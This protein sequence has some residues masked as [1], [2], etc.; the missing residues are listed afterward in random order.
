MTTTRFFNPGGMQNWALLLFLL[1]FTIPGVF[2]QQID[3]MEPSNPAQQSFEEFRQPQQDD[4]FKPFGNSKLQSPSKAPINGGQPIGGLPVSDGI[5]FLSI[6][7]LGFVFGKIF[8]KKRKE[9][10]VKRKRLHLLIGIILTTMM[11]FASPEAFA[12]CT[13]FGLKSTATTPSLCANSGS[14]T[15]QL[16]KGGTATGAGLGGLTNVKYKLVKVSDGSTVVNTTNVSWSNDQFTINNVPFGTFRVDMEATCSGTIN[17]SLASVSVAGH[18]TYGEYKGMNI[19]DKGIAN[20]LPC[21]PSGVYNAQIANGRA[22][23]SVEV[24]KG[25]TTVTTKTVNNPNEDFSVTGLAS[26]SYTM[27]ITD[28]CNGTATQS[29]TVGALSSNFPGSITYNTE[30]T[31]KVFPGSCNEVA[32]GA[33]LVIDA[34][35]NP[36]LA[37]FWNNHF[38]EYYEVA[39]TT[40]ST[41]PA[42]GSSEW[43]NPS[44]LQDA[45]G[46]FKYILPYD[47]YKAARDAGVKAFYLHVRVKSSTCTKTQKINFYSP[48]FTFDWK[49]G[50]GANAC[51]IVGIDFS[52][53]GWEHSI[54]CFPLKMYVFDNATAAAAVS[55]TTPTTVG[56]NNLVFYQ[57]NIADRDQLSDVIITGITGGNR[58]YIRIVDASGEVLKGMDG[59]P[60]G[61]PGTN[62]SHQWEGENGVAGI[63][64]PV[65]PVSEKHFIGNATAT[66]C[67]YNASRMYIGVADHHG[68]W[69]TG[70]DVNVLQKGTTI[71]FI[72][73]PSGTLPTLLASKK[74]QT[75]TTSNNW[76]IFDVFGWKEID[77]IGNIKAV[78]GAPEGAYVFEVAGPCQATQ[79]VTIILKNPQIV[80]NPYTTQQVCAGLKVTFGDDKIT[81]QSNLEYNVNANDEWT[82]SDG[83]PVQVPETLPMY[84]RLVDGPDVVKNANGLPISGAIINPVNGAN[85]VVFAAN[86]SIILTKAGTYK[87]QAQ[88]EASGDCLY[89]SYF[90][91]TYTPNPIALD[92]AYGFVC[93]GDITTANIALKAKNGSGKYKY[94]FVNA[95]GNPLSGAPAAQTKT[96]GTEARFVG[97]GN[98]ND[99]F[100]IKI[101]DTECN[102][103]IIANI[104]M[105]DVQN[106]GLLTVAE[107]LDICSGSTISLSAI[108]VP[109]TVTYEWTKPDG[110]KVSGQ[111]LTIPNATAAMNGVYTIHV[112][113]T[114]DCYADLTD[115]VTINV[116]PSFNLGAA[117]QNLCLGNTL[118]I[119]ASVPGTYIWKKDGLEITGQTGQTLTISN[120]S[121]LD[122]G[123]YTATR[124]VCDEAVTVNITDCFAIGAVNDYAVTPMNTPVTI[125]ELANDTWGS[126]ITVNDIT[127]TQ[128]Q[129]PSV[130]GASVS[131]DGK[132]FVYTPATDF[133][134]RDSIQYQIN[135]NGRNSTAWIYVTIRNNPD[136]IVD[137]DCEGTPS[138]GFDI[139]LRYK[140][141]LAGTTGTYVDYIHEMDVPLVG[142]VDGDGEVEILAAGSVQSGTSWVCNKIH[143]FKGATGELKKIM[144][145]SST[146]DFTKG[147]TFRAMTGTRAIANIDGKVKLFIAG[148]GDSRYTATEGRLVCYDIESGN[149]EWIS[150]QAYALANRTGCNIL[151][152]DVN[153]DGTPE[154]VVNDRIFNAKTGNLLLD[155]NIH[156]TGT[157][158]GYGYGAGHTIT[159]QHVS[160]FPSV[161]DMDNDGKLEFVAGNHI[162]KL[163]IKANSNST[164]DNSKLLSKTAATATNVGDGATAIADI[165]GDGYLDVIVTRHTAA[166]SGTPLTTKGNAVLYAWNGK[167]GELFGNPV[168]VTTGN[169][170]FY[171]NGP[172]IPFIGDIDGDGKPE[173][174]LTTPSK[175]YAYK[176]NQ[177]TN[178]LEQFWNMT[179]TDAS[180]ST[181]LTMFDFN[182]DGKMKLVYRDQ[183]RLKVIDGSTS[184]PVDLIAGKTDAVCFSD[185]QNEYPVVADVT[186]DGR[187]NIVVFGSANTTD[188]SAGKGSVYVYEHVPGKP[189]APSRK[190]WNQW[191][192]NAV[193]VNNDLTIPKVQANPATIFENSNCSKRPYNAF[194][195]Q[196]T[197][198]KENGCPMWAL[199]TLEWVGDPTGNMNGTSLEISG[200]IV[201]SGK[202]GIKAPLYITVY[203]NSVSTANAL[204][205]YKLNEDVLVGKEK[206]FII[207]VINFDTSIEHLIIR[208]N[209]NTK[210]LDSNAATQ[211]L[212]N[213]PGDKTLD[214]SNPKTIQVLTCLPSTVIDALAGKSFGTCS[215][216]DL[217]ASDLS[218]TSS[219]GAAVSFNDDKKLVYSYKQ[220]FTGFDIVN[221]S[222]VCN[223]TTYPF[224]VRIEVTECP[225][226]IVIADCLGTPTAFDW[227]IVKEMEIGSGK[228]ANNNLMPH[229][230]IVVGD[231]NNDG[232]PDIAGVGNEWPYPVKIFWGP[233]FTSITKIT[234]PGSNRLA[235]EGIAIAK[236]KIGADK[237]TTLLFVQGGK[238]VANLG[239][240]IIRADKLYAY[241]PLHSATPYWSADCSVTGMANVADFN[242]DG[243]SE[244]F[245]GNIIYDAATGAKLCDGGSNNKGAMQPMGDADLTAVPQAA[246]IFGLGYLSLIA[247][248][249]IYDVQLNSSRAA[250]SGTMT[251]AK[252][253]TPPATGCGDGFTVVADFDNDSKMEV[254][255]RSMKPRTGTNAYSFEDSWLYLW[256]PHTDVPKILAQEKERNS[257]FGVP[258][259]G[260]ING[261]RKAEIVTLTANGDPDVQNGFRA[262]R[263]NGGANPATAFTSLWNINHKD[264][265]GATGM[266]LFDFN[267][268]GKMEIVYRDENSLDI[269]DGSTSTPTVL[270]STPC[271]SAT[272]IEYPVIADIFN[273][274]H[275]HIITVSDYNELE[276]T[277]TNFSPFSDIGKIRIYGGGS[278]PWAPARP[279]WN[280][281]S[282][283]VVN[284]NKDLTIPQ[285]QINPARIFNGGTCGEVQPYN[286][287]LVQQGLLNKYGCPLWLLPEVT[288]KSAN[289]ALVNSR[290]DLKVEGTFTNS[291]DASFVAPIYISVYKN[292]VSGGNAIYTGKYNNPLAIGADAT[293]SFTIPNIA[294]FGSIETII[295]RVNDNAKELDNNAPVQEI[296][297]S[298]IARPLAFPGSILAVDDV[299]VTDKPSV[300]INVLNNDDLGEYKN[301]P[302]TIIIP[303]P[304]NTGYP[305][306]GTIQVVDGKII[307]TPTAGWTGNDKFT[308]TIR[309]EDP[310]NPGT[311][312]TSTADVIIYV[313]KAVDD[314][315][316]TSKNVP[317]KV[318]ELNNDLLAGL[319]PHEV[320]V[321]ENPNDPTDSRNIKP[322]HGTVVVNDDLTITYT[323]NSGYVGNDEFSYWVSVPNGNGGYYWTPAIVHVTISDGVLDAIDD[324]TVTDSKTPVIIP[325]LDNDD[326]GGRT[327]NDP[328]VVV[329]IPNSGE[330]GYPGH[331]DIKV[332]SD[333]TITYTPNDPDWTGVDKFDY[334]LTTPEG[335]DNA[336][337][338]VIVLKPEAPVY[339]SCPND[340]VVMSVYNIPNVTF[341]WFRQS[342]GGTILSNTNSLTVTKNGLNAVES[343]FVEPAY[344]E[345]G[346]TMTFSRY[347]VDV[348]LVPGLMYW[349]QNA[350]DHNWNNPA[351]WV[352]ISGN[353]LLDAFGKSFIYTVPRACTDVHIPGNAVSYPSLDETNTGRTSVYGNP[354]CHD[355][356]YHFGGEVAKPHELSYH[357]A[358]VHYNFGH[359]A[360][361]T[362]NGTVLNGD[363]SHSAAPMKRGRWYTLS[364]PLK[365]IVTGDFSVGG[366]PNMWQMGFK[367]LRN[368]AGNVYEGTWYSP[369]NKMAIDIDKNLN[370][371]ISLYA[372][373]MNEG[374]LGEGDHKNLNGL[375]GIFKI[376]YFEDA[377]PN[378]YHRL[379]TKTAEGSRFGYYWYDSEGLPLEPGMFDYTARDYKSYRFIFEKADDT[380]DNNF[381][382]DVPVTVENGSASYVMVANPFIS[383]FDF[384]Q[385]L[386]ENSSLLD[387]HYLLYENGVYEPYHPIAGEYPLI[388]PLQAFFIKPAILGGNTSKLI[389]KKEFSVLRGMNESHQL[390]S[391]SGSN[392]ILKI[393]AKNSTGSSRVL[394]SFN[395]PVSNIERLFSTDNPAIPQ[396][397]SLD[398]KQS[399]N[400][401]QFVSES[402]EV[403]IPLGIFTKSTGEFELAFENIENLPLESIRLRDKL[404]VSN[405]YT[406]LLQ[407]NK[408][409][410]TNPAGDLSDRFELVIK[411]AASGID[412]Q[413]V[414]N[415]N[416]YATGR[417]LHVESNGIISEI[418]VTN[419]QGLTVHSDFSVDSNLFTEDLMVPA[420]VYIVS[421]KL[422]TG[423]SKTGKIILK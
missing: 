396:I 402:E 335:S 108:A 267:R 229:I 240:T 116:V 352:N 199:P 160:Q 130:T 242:H 301:Q 263:Y 404:N 7:A 91:I 392:G 28:A 276:R 172:S 417:V 34:N 102:V 261:D 120:V 346:N 142:D 194:L 132:N 191:A 257:M 190:V 270:Y 135:G 139:Q 364:A 298:D 51:K 19:V 264:Q 220:G 71:K 149:R 125:D 216:N 52:T 78:V 27:T 31:K 119:T 201:A 20:T 8:L 195:Q 80:Q 128:L 358:F 184:T 248:N 294:S 129:G 317:V 418:Q 70:L 211:T 181:A 226:N 394:L 385:F 308:Y 336:T 62:S 25:S 334:T 118:T 47:S 272:G 147:V 292:S 176:Y 168:L 159:N 348:H 217:K 314:Y 384:K 72:G 422:K 85:I 372:E 101:T 95:S 324:H 29:F 187:A 81:R 138:T 230:P 157:N 84:Y 321:F 48:Y 251:V 413:K 44:T 66:R 231:L 4:S 198:L 215:V 341:R 45:D 68:E 158:D 97:F 144:D 393:T 189:W 98:L 296:C 140:N 179:S 41:A 320:V 57:G 205:T 355:I 330:S 206:G 121:R 167:T 13:G 117:T 281:Y 293:F 278:N 412:E 210:G 280:Q 65:S 398:A 115:Q 241:D 388:A 141:I 77:D 323:P 35:E 391:A 42:S 137:D 249:Q 410:F 414:N 260:D 185:T 381:G 423:E 209:D 419:V 200:T 331:G 311:Y 1:L 86:T 110:T 354:E 146:S 421:A 182:H 94:E 237:D 286:G 83:A 40:S 37:Y 380:P 365:N 213:T 370:Y 46:D 351:N 113:S 14:I 126:G 143:I 163:D 50:T 192:Y 197:L 288:W 87:F 378:G 265:S 332:N 329:T 415:V 327:P 23:Y 273:D 407:N 252:T 16:T 400:A 269:F 409:V 254:L 304:G 310:E 279:V 366:F 233:T 382:I 316:Y 306:N 223:G 420:G 212:C 178:K 156:G 313:I 221:S 295:I 165:N 271:Y 175:V 74:N 155:M 196:Q 227:S 96:D 287:F 2:A 202:V 148:A 333:N 55:S 243:W 100:R 291:G 39:I 344:T 258:F 54:M 405:E 342:T 411:R 5:W 403:R 162:Y 193:N 145:F 3:L 343:W 10:T 224:S 82:W 225:D 234:L 383:S 79:T 6:C 312:I 103:S 61:L 360:S 359:F 377:D 12:Q 395:E 239:T 375:K 154:I 93:P 124:G 245:V 123:V 64:V 401:I 90:T 183:N 218:A 114:V 307:Y 107:K 204:V 9:D 33:P 347:Q 302:V 268:D 15:L 177:S 111:T 246:D 325:V 134:G 109:G 43:K 353:P 151:I 357:Y 136:N 367:S 92:Y 297:N 318:K 262:R 133:A 389:F 24:K 17:F 164:T 169:T 256:T 319:T 290:A 406:D 376:P 131:M 253:V 362:V 63:Y 26:G 73:W 222:V 338:H 104:T 170:L 274:G 106:M 53:G 186:G 397:Y 408:Y 390:K 285:F 76:S 22:P 173:I 56:Q 250:N 363:A 349:K 322:L 371:A 247:G 174:C 150:D 275:A 328:N 127:V 75:Y 18:P 36:S 207:P 305:T 152:A 361:N 337:V 203:K 105:Q 188:A 303:N 89:G 122:E 340:N 350:I 309:V 58:Y 266:S 11:S 387:N 219:E 299:M 368:Q 153:A 356:T 59:P 255:V 416:I 67:T 60:S 315:V 38:S 69:D 339:L 282:Y 374:V 166:P 259:V 238:E 386:L 161:A 399:R 30:A 283:N 99:N 228:A 300:T 373:P 32:F 88:Q 112:T 369:E 289:V 326:L 236:V 284:V 244:V 379:H 345:N 277:P 180:G 21:S 235:M 171:G 208:L 49:L 214:F 232:N